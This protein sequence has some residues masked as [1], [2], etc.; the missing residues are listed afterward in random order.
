MD[1]RRTDTLRGDIERLRGEFATSVTRLA[2][3]MAGTVDWRV[4]V[5]RRPW[6]YVSGALLL[7][8][9]LGTR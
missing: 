8:V 7:G 3:T 1:D 9:L 4:R 2:D 5:R 6:A